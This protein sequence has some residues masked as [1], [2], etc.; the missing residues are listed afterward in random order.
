MA[1]FKNN[2]PHLKSQ[3]ERS[4]AKE[5]IFLYNNKMQKLFL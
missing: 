1:K 4:K 5:T 2:L 3:G